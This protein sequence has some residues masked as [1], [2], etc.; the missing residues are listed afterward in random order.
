MQ[1]K[2]VWRSRATCAGDEYEVDRSSG[3]EYEIQLK[4]AGNNYS[5]YADFKAYKRICMRL[6][7]TP[8]FVIEKNYLF[9]G[10]YYEVMAMTG[11]T[12]YGADMLDYIFRLVAKYADD[13]NSLYLARM[14]WLMNCECEDKSYSVS[15]VCVLYNMLYFMALLKLDNELRLLKI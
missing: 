2:D 13:S 5:R 3:L 7:N 4:E 10:D 12:V 15:S 8:G 6:A 9:E 11:G 1:H 14:S